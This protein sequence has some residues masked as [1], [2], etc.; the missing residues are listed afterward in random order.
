M[1]QKI[2][3][4]RLG[5]ERI[6]HRGGGIGHELHVRLV[7]RLPAGDRRAVEHDAVGESLFVHDSTSMVTCCILPRGS[8]KRR[9]TNFT[10]L[11]LIF[12]RSY[13]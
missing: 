4:V 7:D 10:S 8:V 11:S 9:S 6:D 12:F 2:A 3:S 5:E 13:S 1:S